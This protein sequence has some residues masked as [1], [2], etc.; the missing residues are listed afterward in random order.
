ME[1]FSLP[2]PKRR[3][4]TAQSAGVGAAVLP[5]PTGVGQDDLSCQVRQS[6]GGV[7][8]P[9]VDP[10]GRNLPLWITAEDLATGGQ[11]VKVGQ[12]TPS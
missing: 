10:R 3:L 2:D 6:R 8:I 11:I 9:Q 1:N 7:Q 4:R 12:H 5:H